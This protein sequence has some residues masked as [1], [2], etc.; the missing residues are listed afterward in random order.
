MNFLV[1]CLTT[2]GSFCVLFLVAKFIGRKQISQL[3]F[4]DYITGITI[5]S[6]AAEMAT[7][8]EEPWKPL[9]AMVIYGGV[10]LLLS[11]VSNK[12]P[13]TRKYLNGAPTILM[14]H[15][16]LYYQNLKKAKLDLSEFM[17]MCRQQ[18]YFDLTNIET[19]VFEYNGKLTILPVSSQRPATPKDMDLAPE[20][21]LF[22]TEL[23]MDGR[24]LEDNLKRMGLDLTWLDKQLK[25]RHIRSPKDVVL[26]VCDP[27]LKFFLFEKNPVEK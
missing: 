21:E 13:R 25:Q 2:F 11:V 19:A 27:N 14:D 8:L 23:I 6:I 3:D 4:F 17:V 10:T 26:A 18:G 7:E 12:F 15:G 9:T 22:F 1:L 24:I 20:Q 5:G 16:K